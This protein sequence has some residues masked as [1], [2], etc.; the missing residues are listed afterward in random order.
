MAIKV[1]S[2]NN[3]LV[4]FGLLATAFGGVTLY[5]I[6]PALNEQPVS[7]EAVSVLPP[8]VVALGRLEPASAVIN[9]SVP[10][11]LEGDRIA[12]LLVTEG[13]TVS[14]GQI[15]AVLDSKDRLAQLVAESQAQLQAAERSLALVRAGEKEGAIAAQRATIAQ[16]EADLSGALSAQSATLVR[17][18]AEQRNAQTE[19]RRF[20]QLYQ[21]GAVS[22]STRDEKQVAL[23]TLQ[24]QVAEAEAERVRSR[25]TLQSE[26]TAAQA[27][28]N[29]ISEVRPED[30]AV[31]QAEVNR[32]TEALSLAKTNLSQ[33]D[34][35]A[36]LDGTVIKIHSYPGEKIAE[37]GIVELGQTQA[38][39]VVAEVDESD[40]QQV[41]LG[42]T[43]QVTGPAFTGEIQGTIER[44][45]QAVSRQSV[46]SNEPGSNL[47]NRVVEVR[48]ALDPA[49]SQQV[50]SLTN[51]QVDV[52]IAPHEVP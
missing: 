18:Q 1:W 17:L 40:I 24:A 52:A 34:I 11:T 43:A 10:L 25:Q 38:M 13:E 5:R 4:G 2:K 35:R 51:L 30:I 37:Q 3:W 47:D 42:Q 12:K 15:I 44:I 50:A 20:A 7:P 46:F 21:Q 28:L 33:A 23:E 41:Q 39:V 9:L 22:A 26:I 45:G 8:T 36:P 27:T 29:E 32:A 16:L 6:M 14:A 19:Y 49:E 48:I 31:A